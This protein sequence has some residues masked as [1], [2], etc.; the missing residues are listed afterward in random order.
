MSRIEH[1]IPNNENELEWQKSK[2]LS[3]TEKYTIFE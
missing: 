1:N 2:R 3:K